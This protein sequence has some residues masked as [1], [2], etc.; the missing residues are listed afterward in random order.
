M[1]YS[2]YLPIRF[3]FFRVSASAAGQHAT[4]GKSELLKI[5]E[6][7]LEKILPSSQATVQELLAQKIP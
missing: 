1:K 6:S 2:V 3:I 4:P 7:L 5:P